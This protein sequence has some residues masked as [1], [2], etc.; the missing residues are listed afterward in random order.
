MSCRDATRRVST[1]PSEGKSGPG[2]SVYK[3]GPDVN[4]GAVRP[5]LAAEV[6]E[7]GYFKWQKIYLFVYFLRTTNFKF[8]IQT[9]LTS[10]NVSNFF[11]FLFSY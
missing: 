5:P 4:R 11:R 9:N 7:K 1:R 3:L 2:I 6:D 8:V 10:V